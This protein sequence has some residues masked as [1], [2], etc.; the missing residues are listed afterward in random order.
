MFTTYYYSADSMA[1]F[2]CSTRDAPFH[3]LATMPQLVY[4][5]LVPYSPIYFGV[6][7]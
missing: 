5:E 4:G 3:R 1:V 2:W 7:Q 6:M